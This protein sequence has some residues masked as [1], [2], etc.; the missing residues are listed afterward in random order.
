MKNS[1]HLGAGGPAL[2]FPTSATGVSLA[3]P[4]SSLGF[5]FLICNEGAIIKNSVTY[6]SL[7]NPFIKKYLS[8][9]LAIYDRQNV[10]LL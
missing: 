3:S 4:F 6:F 8:G 1:T 7:Q 10:K 9:K 2:V 5:R